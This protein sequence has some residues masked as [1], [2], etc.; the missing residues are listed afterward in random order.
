MRRVFESFPSIGSTWLLAMASNGGVDG[1]QVI[2]RGRPVSDNSSPRL[3][4]V[5]SVLISKAMTF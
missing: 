4:T 3:D 1:I 2:S 5:L